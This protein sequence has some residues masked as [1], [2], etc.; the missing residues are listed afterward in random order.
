MLQLYFANILDRISLSN[1]NQALYLIP[2]FLSIVGFGVM[3]ELRGLQSSISP[4]SI[5]HWTRISWITYLTTLVTVLGNLGYN[6]YRSIE[7]RET[8]YYLFS[9]VLIAIYYSVIYIGFFRETGE[10]HFH[11]WW[12]CHMLGFYFRYD[13]IWNNTMSMI[14]Y[15][16][17]IQ[18]IIA[19]GADHIFQ[20]NYIRQ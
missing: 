9:M 11:H 20:S 15:G 6:I 5:A 2:F 19:Y 10:L 16:I 12:I 7:P 13:S 8:F 14:V 1:S 4:S 18:G 17:S 3:G